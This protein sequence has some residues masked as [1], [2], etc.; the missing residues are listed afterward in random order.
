MLDPQISDFLSVLD[1]PLHLPQPMYLTY[2][3]SYPCMCLFDGGKADK[4]LT[5]L[6]ISERCMPTLGNH[7][8]YS[9]SLKDHFK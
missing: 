6:F 1:V 3:L 2:C 5:L 9:S 7:S 8:L 4:H